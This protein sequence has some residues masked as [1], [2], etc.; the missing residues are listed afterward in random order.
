MHEYRPEALTF[1]SQHARGLG[2]NGASFVL[3]AFGIING[4]IRRSI[5]DDAWPNVPNQDTQ[6]FGAREVDLGIVKRNHLAQRGQRP[7]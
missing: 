6:S 4:S 5:D 2:I 1:L 7:V 3:F